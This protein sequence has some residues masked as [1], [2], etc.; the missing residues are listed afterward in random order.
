LRFSF[1]FHFS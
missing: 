1:Q